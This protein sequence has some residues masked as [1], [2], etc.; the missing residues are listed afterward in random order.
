[1][2]EFDQ[3]LDACGLSCPLP[4]LRARKI[5]Q[6]MA[7]GEVL[8]I[9]ATDPGSVIDFQTFSSKN[10]HQLLESREED[11]VYYYLLRKA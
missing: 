3:E 7:S 2:A 6:R 1:M 10:G 5:L 4:I 8:H 11:G 9:T